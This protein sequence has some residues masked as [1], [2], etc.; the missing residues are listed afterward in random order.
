MPYSMIDIRRK[1]YGLQQIRQILRS[2]TYDELLFNETP[3]GS[4]EHASIGVQEG[5][6]Q[7]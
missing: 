7:R 2:C 5:L 1:G 6:G 4:A 3:K